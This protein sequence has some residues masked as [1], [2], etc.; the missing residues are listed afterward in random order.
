MKWNEKELKIQFSTLEYLQM[1]INYIQTKVLNF[2]V[3][4]FFCF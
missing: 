1:I 2:L 3:F 4:N